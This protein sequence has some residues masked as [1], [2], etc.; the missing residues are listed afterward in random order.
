M[1]T[2]L[3]VFIP[4]NTNNVFRASYVQHL[5]LSKKTIAREA[6]QIFGD[7]RVAEHKEQ[8]SNEVNRL[9]SEYRHMEQGAPVQFMGVCHGVTQEEINTLDA[10]IVLLSSS[11]MQVRGSKPHVSQN[12]GTGV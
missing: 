3:C 9:V 4:L 7:K 6:D 8:L 10:H 2:Y 1:Y 5:P 12:W 11:D